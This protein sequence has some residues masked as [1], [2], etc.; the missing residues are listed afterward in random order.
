VST[1][2]LRLGQIAKR[3]R[4]ALG[5]TIAEVA[6]AAGITPKTVGKI[7]AGSP[8]REL[9][10]WRLNAGLDWQEGSSQ[11]V[12][13][14]GEPLPLEAAAGRPRYTRE[15]LVGALGL[16]HQIVDVAEV[17]DAERSRIHE[18]ISELET[19]LRMLVTA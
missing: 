10:L 19:R 7:E 13:S 12:L 6:D 15:Q 9:T 11:A 16:L 14:G 2:R 5:R 3:R 4:L 8:V 18:R 17:S 1:D